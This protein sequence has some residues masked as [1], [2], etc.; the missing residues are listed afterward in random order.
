MTV[1]KW[2][3]HHM[4]AYYPLVDH[5]ACNQSRPT[6]DNRSISIKRRQMA[7]TGMHEGMH[8]LYI[9]H[10]SFVLSVRVCLDVWKHGC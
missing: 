1:Q 5:I 8:A 10:K 6:E 4:T 7:C 9:V 3:S 2:Q